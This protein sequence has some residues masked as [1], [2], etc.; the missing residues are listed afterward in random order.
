MRFSF[1]VGYTYLMGYLSNAGF[2]GWWCVGDVLGVSTSMYDVDH[3][4][5]S[6]NDYLILGTSLTKINKKGRIS[7]QAHAT[8]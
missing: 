6:F 1:A 7:V 2:D 8:L 3:P 4:M 5:Y